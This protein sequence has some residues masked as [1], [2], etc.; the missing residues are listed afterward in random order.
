MKDCFASISTL[1]GPKNR[2][3]KMEMLF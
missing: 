3:D 2:P 1:L